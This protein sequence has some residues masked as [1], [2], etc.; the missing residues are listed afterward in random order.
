MSPIW[1]QAINVLKNASWSWLRF[2]QHP[3]RLFQYLLIKNCFNICLLKKKIYWDDM[4]YNSGT[5][6]LCVNW[7]ER[8][9]M[10]FVCIFDWLS[11]SEIEYNNRLCFVLLWCDNGRFNPYPFGL[12]ATWAM[13]Q[14]LQSHNAPV[15]YPT[16]HQSHIP[17]CIIL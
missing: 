6:I 12:L 15:P 10:W 16:M 1:L 5:S 14:I 7:D 17:Q 8:D 9:L 13:D 2:I 4:R 11:Y 3:I